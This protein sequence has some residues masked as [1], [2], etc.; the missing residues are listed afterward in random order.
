MG[1]IRFIIDNDT[2]TLTTDCVR[3]YPWHLSKFEKDV[4]PY[5]KGLGVIEK[6]QVP[7]E[8]Q[9]V[10]RAMQV[11]IPPEEIYTGA[12]GMQVPG[13]MTD[14]IFGV[15]RRSH[16]DF[17]FLPTTL[18]AH[19]HRAW[20][21]HKYWTEGGGEGWFGPPAE[22]NAYVAGA[23]INEEAAQKWAEEIAEHP[24][25]KILLENPTA[26]FA[27]VIK[28]RVNP[29]EWEGVEVKSSS[30]RLLD[31]DDNYLLDTL[32][33]G[34][35]MGVYRSYNIA[36]GRWSGTVYV[37]APE[38]WQV[39]RDDNRDGYPLTPSY[40]ILRAHNGAEEVLLTGTDEDQ[41]VDGSC[42]TRYVAELPSRK[43]YSPIDASGNWATFWTN[44]KAWQEFAFAH[45]IKARKASTLH[46]PDDWNEEAPFFIPLTREYAEKAW[47]TGA[48]KL[49]VESVELKA[50][51]FEAGYREGD[52]LIKDEANPLKGA[53]VHGKSTC[54]FLPSGYPSF[55]GWIRC[56][57]GLGISHAAVVRELG[58][59][60]RERTE[61]T[62]FTD[63]SC[64]YEQR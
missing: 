55:K 26:P 56:E 17:T 34:C 4:D 18:T 46:S 28:E 57:K 14:A 47:D 2:L 10:F 3:G 49:P 30:H 44:R 33:G 9:L 32:G 58:D 27:V 40:L 35:P 51:Q 23:W 31:A 63:G 24:L 13:A 52:R 61:I 60:S 39:E 48:T 36:F 54:V 15:G 43:P 8:L 59:E 38:L 7:D 19:G 50:S 62:V 22:H 53:H 21:M 41:D 5:D 64:V 12:I 20:V 42:R 37:H 1:S 16:A 29:A 6:K 25:G 11:A 45:H